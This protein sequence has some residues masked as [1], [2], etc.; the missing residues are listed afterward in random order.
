M[1]VAAVEVGSSLVMVHRTARTHPPQAISI[2]NSTATDKTISLWITEKDVER[3]DQHLFLDEADLRS[4][5]TVII[6]RL[7][8]PRLIEFEEIWAQGSAGST[9]TILVHA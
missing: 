1:I 3:G 5:Q 6:G 7:E 4:K 9:F 2:C 8:L